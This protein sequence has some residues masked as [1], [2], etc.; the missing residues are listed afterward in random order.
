MRIYEVAY[1]STDF[2]TGKP[3]MRYAHCQAKSINDVKDKLDN[4]PIDPLVPDGETY[5]FTD[6]I[7]IEKI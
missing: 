4:V 3:I 2:I 5:K 7:S 1:N 6:Y